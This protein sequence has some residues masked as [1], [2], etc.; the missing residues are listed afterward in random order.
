MELREALSQISE[1]RA[2][3]ARTE[4]F[5]GY[6]SVTVGSSGLL[7]LAGA[8]VQAVW[9]PE[10]GEN[11]GAYLA[12]WIGIAAA[13]VVICGGEMVWRWCRA[14]SPLTRQVTLL[15]VEQFL[16]CIVAGGLTTYAIVRFAGESRGMESL[17][18]LPGLWAII[19]SLGVFAS[20]RLLPKLVFAVATYYL[21]AGIAVLAWARG[22]AALSPWAMAGTFGIGQLLAAA[23]LHFTLERTHARR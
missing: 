22:D 19:F 6:R 16:P 13:S 18:I 5:R 17:G 11:I 14:A 3:M 10:P 12:L 1:I 15:A 23:I 8:G 4:T 9:I 20:C 2:Q 7:A 21:T